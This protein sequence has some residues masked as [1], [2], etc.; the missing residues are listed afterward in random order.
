M[1]ELTASL[2]AVGGLSGHLASI[3]GL[4][5]VIAVGA[6]SHMRYDGAYSFT[7]SEE[8]QTIRIAD[9][10]A[11]ADIIIEP[12]PNTYGRIERTGSIITV[13]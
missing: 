8:A 12:I 5:G 6:D 9:R 10:V 2:S 4:S 11:V 3:G 1:Q 13:Y 7:P